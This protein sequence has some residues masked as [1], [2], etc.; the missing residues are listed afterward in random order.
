VGRQKWL[1]KGLK[2]GFGYSRGRLK[3]VGNGLGN[4]FLNKS[5]NNALPQAHTATFSRQG[6]RI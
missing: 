4:R 1:E 3:M 2:A 6:S 5:R